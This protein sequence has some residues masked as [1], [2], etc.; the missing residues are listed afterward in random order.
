MLGSP[1][2]SVCWYVIE[3]DRHGSCII[4]DGQAGTQE[5]IDGQFLRDGKSSHDCES[6]LSTQLDNRFQI[7]V[8]VFLW[9][10]ATDFPLQFAYDLPLDTR[11]DEL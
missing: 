11:G 4:T 3:F 1:L 2:F 7:Q 8:S 9:S 6:L 10:F 5:A